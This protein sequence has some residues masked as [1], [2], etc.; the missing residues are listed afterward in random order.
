MD[1]P[2]FFCS[3]SGYSPFFGMDPRRIR[4][5]CVMVQ[6]WNTEKTESVFCADTGRKQEII[7][8]LQP[9]GLQGQATMSWVGGQSKAL[10]VSS[11]VLSMWVKRKPISAPGHHHPTFTTCLVILLLHELI[12]RLEKSDTAWEW[13]VWEWIVQHWR[14]STN[15][16]VRLAGLQP[17]AWPIFL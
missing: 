4:F 8:R 9:L 11:G 15:C 10:S 16:W 14:Y 13:G 3:H 17:Y 6:K 5:S 1:L 2:L 12:N 7:W